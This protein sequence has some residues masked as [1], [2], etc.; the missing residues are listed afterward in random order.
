VAGR[1]PG[2]FR[3]LSAG[4]FQRCRIAH[5]PLS[6]A[7]LCAPGRET[8]SILPASMATTLDQSRESAMQWYTARVASERC[9]PAKH[10]ALKTATA[11]RAVADTIDMLDLPDDV[12][13]HNLAQ[14]DHAR[15]ARR[16]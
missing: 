6:G 4:G 16:G 2:C 12:L 13:E 7:A 3:A 1:I 10:S 5:Q 9:E 8:R 14:L 11:T 15:L